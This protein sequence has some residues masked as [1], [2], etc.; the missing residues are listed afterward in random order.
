[1]NWNMPIGITGADTMV[2]F[3]S[4]HFTV[5]MPKIRTGYKGQSGRYCP[6]T[7]TLVLGR[8]CTPFT[9]AH[10]FSHYLFH[11]AHIPPKPKRTDPEYVA[12]YFRYKKAKRGQTQ[13]EW[14]SQG[15]YYKLR[16]VIKAIGD[17]YFYPWKKEYKQ[18]K[19][20]ASMDGLV[21]F[22]ESPVMEMVDGG[23]ELT[24]EHVDKCQ[25]CKREVE[26]DYGS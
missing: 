26:L 23:H 17:D 24:D 6:R 18:L 2:R 5:R 25:V 14:H 21:E 9:V 4:T 7:K 10:E 20:W 15:F 12:K 3:L 13:K 19:R 11:I 16:G 1:M 22:V 8:G